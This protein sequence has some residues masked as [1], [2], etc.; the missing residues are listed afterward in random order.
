MEG[1]RYAFIA[2]F[3]RCD[4]LSTGAAREQKLLQTV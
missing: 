1:R 3:N 4:A 2:G